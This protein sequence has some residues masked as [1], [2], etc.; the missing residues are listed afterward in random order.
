MGQAVF[1]TVGTTA[2][3]ALV[4]ELLSECVLALLAGQG[5]QRLVLQLGRG[6]E[7]VLPAASPLAIDWYRFKPSLEED[8]RGASLIISHAGAGS[9]LEGMALGARMV[10]VVNDALMH[11]HQRELAD[12]LHARAHLVATVPSGLADTLRE[13]GERPPSLTPMPPAEPSAFSRFLSAQLGLGGG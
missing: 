11:N 12:E 6:A 3:D 13:L 9:I 8:M 1:A 10:V 7:P 2:F 4:G 5:Y